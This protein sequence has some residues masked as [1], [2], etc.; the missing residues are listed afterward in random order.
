MNPQYLSWQ[1]EQNFGREIIDLIQ[2]GSREAMAPVIDRL[3]QRNALL[4]DHVAQV[5]QDNLHRQVVAAVP[6][7]AEINQNPHWLAW[8]SQTEPLNGVPRQQ[9]LNDAVASGDARR[10]INFFRGFL[11]ETGQ[12][13]QPAHPAQ[14]GQSILPSS[15]PAQSRGQFITR[16]QILQMSSLHRQGKIS[17]ADYAKWEAELC[18]ASKEG[19]ILGGEPLGGLGSL[20]PRG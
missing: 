9:L 5:V 12:P 11:Q 8:L 20:M 17:D 3:E 4:G 15:Y 18:R 10:V 19:R 2:R 7:W 16:P 14:P 1:D 6:Q 13:A